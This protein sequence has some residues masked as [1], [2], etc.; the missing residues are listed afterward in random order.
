MR[1]AL[2]IKG[3]VQ[4][5]GYRDIIEKNARVRRLRG[6]V[7][8]DIDGTVK[9]VCDGAEEK[10]DEFIE[11][12]NLHEEDIF[13][14]DILKSEVEDVSPIPATF[15]RLQTDM[16]EDI[17]R[18]L[19]RYHS[20]EGYKRGYHSIEGYKRGYHSIEGYKIGYYRIG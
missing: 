15:A 16:L 2:T 7:F 18:K 13:V 14:E 1:Y 9:L 19:G 20:I 3:R 12:I 5:A 4:N 17:G 10:I 6:Y 11:V 8:N